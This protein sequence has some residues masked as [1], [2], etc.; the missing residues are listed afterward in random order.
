MNTRRNNIPYF[1]KYVAK[2]TDLF[3]NHSAEIHESRLCDFCSNQS[4]ARWV[5]TVQGQVEGDDAQVKVSQGRIAGGRSTSDIPRAPVYMST[6]SCS[7]VTC[8]VVTTLKTLGQRRLWLLI[9]RKLLSTLESP[10]D[11]EDWPWLS[12]RFSCL[13]VLL[14]VH[15]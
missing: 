2:R 11:Q 9:D 4:K 1:F 15:I 5:L 6:I 7:W 8:T 3:V 10:G 12:G 14:G 13:E